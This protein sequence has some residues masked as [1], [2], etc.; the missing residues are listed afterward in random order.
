[1]ERLIQ[2]VNA[3]LLAERLGYEVELER[4]VNDASM[5]TSIKVARIKTLLATMANHNQMSTMWAVYT[6]TPIP[7]SEK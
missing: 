6:S 1:M 5:E 7:E 2:I 3:E 4:I